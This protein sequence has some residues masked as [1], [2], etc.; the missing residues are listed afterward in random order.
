V[1]VPFQPFVDATSGADRAAKGRSAPEDVSAVVVRD[2][3]VLVARVRSG[4]RTAEEQLYRRHAGAVLGLATRLLH[5]RDDAMDVMQDAFVS[6]FENLGSLREPA[7]FRSWLMRVTASLVHRRFRR[8]KL[9]G[10]LGLGGKRDEVALDELADPTIAPE[11]RAELRWLDRRL[12]TL[13]DRDRAAWILRHV[14]GFA[15]EEVAEACGCSL[16]TAKRRIA[17]AEE[18]VRGHFDEGGVR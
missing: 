11:T 17:V 7:A 9:L 14:E 15:L 5:S 18:A 13:S 8:R 4:D 6:V 12:A 16:A 3:E 2:D 10:L 1:T